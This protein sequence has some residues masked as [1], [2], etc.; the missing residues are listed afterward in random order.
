MSIASPGHLGLSSPPR[1]FP[2]KSGTLLYWLWGKHPRS[3][4]L[5]DEPDKKFCI[6]M[7]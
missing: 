6:N 7:T 3:Q 5:E 2:E 4:W 1:R